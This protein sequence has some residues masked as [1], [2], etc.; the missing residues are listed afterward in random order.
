MIMP[1]QV[2]GV[3]AD[4]YEFRIYGVTESGVALWITNGATENWTIM[5]VTEEDARFRCNRCGATYTEKVEICEAC[6]ALGRLGTITKVYPILEKIANEFEA[7]GIEETLNTQLGPKG[8]TPVIMQV[9]SR[10]ITL[11]R[12]DSRKNTITMKQARQVFGTE[13]QI[14]PRET[15]KVTLPTL[16]KGATRLGLGSD[17]MHK[18]RVLFNDT[19]LGIGIRPTG[20][21]TTMS[22]KVIALDLDLKLKFEPRD[23]AIDEAINTLLK[24]IENTFYF[25]GLS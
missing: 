19:M 13:T 25:K 18:L 7:E 8:K 16:P 2:K 1:L 10:L 21:I 20:D 22:E 3:S 24:W 23:Q 5:G 12:V 9:D 11:K 4:G 6:E 15:P 14:Q 17:G